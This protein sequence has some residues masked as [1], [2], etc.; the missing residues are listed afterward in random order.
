M[1]SPG[2]VHSLRS[3]PC[4]TAHGIPVLPLPVSS[5]SLL[6]HEG[7]R[8][9]S[10]LPAVS[11][12]TSGSPTQ[13]HRTQSSPPLAAPREGQP[14]SYLSRHQLAVAPSTARLGTC[15]GACP[16]N[17]TPEPG[18][19]AHTH[20]CVTT[21]TALLVTLKRWKYPPWDLRARLHAPQQT[22][23]VL[24]VTQHLEAPEESGSKSVLANESP[25]E[26]EVT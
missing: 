16:W 24:A 10:F 22:S 2:A 14:A 13:A 25:E 7:A 23:R 3:G 17:T 4:A 19:G 26:A 5:H 9:C 11:P 12:T 6:R 1:L 18:M 8:G 21:P 20:A 15:G